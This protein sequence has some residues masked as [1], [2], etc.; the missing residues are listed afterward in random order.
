MDKRKPVV[1]VAFI[2]LASASLYIYTL[3]LENRRAEVVEPSVKLQLNPLDAAKLVV[4][5]DNDPGLE[6][7]ETAWG[8]SIYVETSSAKLLF[9][10]GPDPGLLEK[11]LGALGVNI[12]SIDAVII[13]HEHLDHAGG[14]AAIARAKPGA[15]V[16]IPAGASPGL[17]ENVEKLGLKPV[18]VNS[19]TMLYRGVAVTAPLYGPPY[20]ISLMIYVKGRGLIVVTGCAHPGVDTIAKYAH[21]VTGLPIYAVVGGFHLV[22]ADTRRLEEITE[23]FKQLGVKE[24]YP[25][26][27]SGEKA[28]LFFAEK[29]GGIYRGGGIGTVIMVKSP[30]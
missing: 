30:T 28:R 8:I 12:A 19:A 21:N 20:E 13:S 16:Y 14:L 24:L 4:V 6:N 29:L 18:E 22:G 7:L 9:D 2:I 23:T 1:A 5:V 10:T 27:C 15:T 3:L 26:H 25:I 11:N 17:K